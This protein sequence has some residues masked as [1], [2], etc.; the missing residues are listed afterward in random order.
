MPRTSKPWHGVC[1]S[2]EAN[3]D[4][5]SLLLLIGRDAVGLPVSFV[6]PA[7]RR[8]FLAIVLSCERIRQHEQVDDHRRCRRR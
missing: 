3:D 5:I 4:S 6:V 1:R 8:A 7:R 2:R